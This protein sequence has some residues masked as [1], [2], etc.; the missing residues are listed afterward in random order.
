MSR[1]GCRQ[2]ARDLQRYL[3]DETLDMVKNLTKDPDDVN[4]EDQSRNQNS[5]PNQETQMSV[6]YT[7]FKL[8]LNAGLNV[9]N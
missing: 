3:Q 8:N 6:L 7:A 2:M 9:L 4:S 1:K 5:L